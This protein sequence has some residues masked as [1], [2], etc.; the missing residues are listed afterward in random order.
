[1][2]A[3]EPDNT[4]TKMPSSDDNDIEPVFYQQVDPQGSTTYV[5]HQFLDTP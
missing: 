1:M 2:I 5:H 4:D 3:F